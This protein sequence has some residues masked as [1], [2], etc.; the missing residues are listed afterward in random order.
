MEA[1]QKRM[2][3]MSKGLRDKR[4]LWIPRSSSI[5]GPVRFTIKN[6]K[7]TALLNASPNQQEDRSFSDLCPNAGGFVILSD[8]PIYHIIFTLPSTPRS[9][10]QRNFSESNNNGPSHLPHQ[11]PAQWHNT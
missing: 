4:Y 2:G 11:R 6:N 5:C 3:R 8:I 9:F 7:T 1:S 10:K